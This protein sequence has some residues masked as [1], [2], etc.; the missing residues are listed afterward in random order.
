MNKKDHSIK[1][2][3]SFH[4]IVLPLFYGKD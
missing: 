3:V 4:K 2:N 1:E